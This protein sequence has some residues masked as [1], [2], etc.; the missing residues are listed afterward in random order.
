MRLWN[1]LHFMDTPYVT[2]ATIP[3]INYTEAVVNS[4]NMLYEAKKVLSINLLNN[5]AERALYARYLVHLLGD[6]HQPLHSAA[7][8][9]HTFKNGDL[10][11]NLLKIKLVNGT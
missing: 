1:A 9:N 6:V 2:D 4:V 11:G 8:F 7:L 3:H 10:G 5:T